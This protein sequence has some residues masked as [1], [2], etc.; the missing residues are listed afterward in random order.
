MGTTTFTTDELN[1]H[2]LELD[3]DLSTPNVLVQYSDNRKKNQLDFI[4]SKEVGSLQRIP[5]SGH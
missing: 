4:K 5:S 2:D 3:N 1:F